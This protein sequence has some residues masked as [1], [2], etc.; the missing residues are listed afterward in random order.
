MLTEVQY[1]ITALKGGSP[2]YFGVFIPGFRETGT[3]DSC[4]SAHNMGK[5]QVLEEQV[6]VFEM[7]YLGFHLLVFNDP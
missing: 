2:V 4:F 5:K 7:L 6:T 1:N 3:F